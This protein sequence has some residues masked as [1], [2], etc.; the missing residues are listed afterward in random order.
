MNKAL[1]KIIKII[2]K[3]DKIIITGHKNPDFDSFSSS[4]GM[5][6]ICKKYNKEA[7]VFIELESI[8][9]SLKKGI[10]KLNESKEIYNL[11][12]SKKAITLI[13]KNTL[14]IVVDFCNKELIECKE[15]LELATLIIDHHVINDELKINS[16][17]EYIDNKASSVSE[18]VTLFIDNLKLKPSELIS[19]LLLVGIEVDTNGYIMKTTS[20]TF[21]ASSILLN[22]NAD[23]KLKAEI[24][25]ETR[26]EYI[27]KTNMIKRSYMFNDN[28]MLCVLDN[29]IYNQKDLAEVADELIQFENVEASFVIGKTE[30]NK[31]SISA[32]SLGNIDVEK[33][34]KQL[35]GGGSQTSAATQIEKINLKETKQKLLQVL[36]EV[37]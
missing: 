29:E 17:F 13:N 20:N 31:V 36:K 30:K 26:E 3:Y 10:E 18:M 15:L 11:I 35:G 14:L 23:N 12:D 6:E 21:L 32:R 2:K 28:M 34:M 8:N 5:Y 24:L 25:K 22:L 19:T 9:E 1:K 4:L 37:K 7:Y 33:I 27:K 16:L